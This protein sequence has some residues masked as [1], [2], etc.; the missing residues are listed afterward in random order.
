M[1]NEEVTRYFLIHNG[2]YYKPDK[3]TKKRL[4]NYIN[5]ELKVIG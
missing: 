2:S 5:G 1:K 3:N 4:P